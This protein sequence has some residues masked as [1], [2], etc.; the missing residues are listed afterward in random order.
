VDA[1]LAEVKALMVRLAEPLPVTLAELGFIVQPRLAD[2]VAQ[3][4]ATATFAE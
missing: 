3:L 2:E 1:A 4:N